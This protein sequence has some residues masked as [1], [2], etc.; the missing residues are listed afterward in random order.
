MRFA[1]FILLLSSFLIANE[2]NTTLNQG[3][4]QDKVEKKK[5]ETKNYIA[6]LN[7]ELEK[8]RNLHIDLKLNIENNLRFQESLQKT[9]AELLENIISEDKASPLLKV[10]LSQPT[11]L[12]IFALPLVT[13]FIVLGSTFLSLRTIK[14]KSKESL[15]ALDRSNENLLRISNNNIQAERLKSQESIISNSRQKW[16]NTLRDELASLM[17]H[18]K[19]FSLSSQKRKDEIFS[20]VWGE[21]FKVELLLNPKEEVHN[22]LIREINIAFKLSTKS[23]HIAEFRKHSAIVLLTSKELLKYEWERVKSFE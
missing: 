8:L 19:Q 14:I 9:T 7:K 3:T 18:L 20:E 23:E 6:D 12:Y 13:I 16:I 11:N 21:L 15:D 22:K 5:L 2:V 17:S 10:Q 4:E 1:V